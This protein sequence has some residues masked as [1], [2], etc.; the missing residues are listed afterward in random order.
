VG[1]F[2]L[3]NVP[4]ATAPNAATL[5]LVV[6]FLFH[7]SGRTETLVLPAVAL[8]LYRAFN[9]LTG[10]PVFESRDALCA[11][12][13]IAPTTRIVLSGTDV[14]APLERWWGLGEAQRRRTIRALKRT[15]IA[16]VTTPNYSL[17]LDVPRWNDL[18]AI[19]RIALVHYE[20]ISEGLPAALHVNGRTEADF[21][22]WTE[23]V[24]AR[25]EVTHLAY[26]F[27]T[28]S[29]WAGRRERHATWLCDLARA[30]SRPLHLTVRGGV[31]VLPE[32]A[33]N[34]AG[35]TILD[36]S[37][38]IKTMMRQRAA[39][40]GGTRVH[41]SSAP[42]ARRASLDSLL[43]HNMPAVGESLRQAATSCTKE[44]KN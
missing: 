33:D 24:A 39:L 16:L 32:L 41:W 5:P 34:F 20:F 42:T 17:F 10:Q 38:F 36:T 25:P 30:V 40:N 21:A 13:R 29:S 23:Y 6:P 2:A 43:M 11:A 26:E 14:D 19:K 15:G 1:T 28:G 9:R 35:I 7:G 37:T 12:Y 27:T 4:R 18:H 22:R 31:E 44:S 8:S 3:D